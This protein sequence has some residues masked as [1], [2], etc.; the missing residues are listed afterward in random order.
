MN[1]L[2]N[3][4]APEG[5]ETKSAES[6][7]SQLFYTPFSNLNHFFAPEVNLDNTKGLFANYPEYGAAHLLEAL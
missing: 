4:Q 5:Y 6:G 3:K 1:S 7:E 2:Y